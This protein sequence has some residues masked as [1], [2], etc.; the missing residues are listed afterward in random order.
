MLC[1][2]YQLKAKKK[3]ADYFIAILIQRGLLLAISNSDWIIQKEPQRYKDEK[4]KI[5]NFLL[6]EHSLM[7]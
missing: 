1:P 6:L 2:L 5:S 3:C 4:E 7:V